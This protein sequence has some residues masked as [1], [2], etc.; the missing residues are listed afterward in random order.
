VAAAAASG[1]VTPAGAPVSDANE[2]RESLAAYLCNAP[3]AATDLGNNHDLFQ[4]LP[5]HFR[6]GKI[7][8]LLST[9]LW[10]RHHA[11][12]YVAPAAMIQPNTHLWPDIVDYCQVITITRANAAV[13]PVN[14]ASYFNF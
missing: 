1:F 4:F 3:D 13:G 9:N 10:L 8:A 12:G 5:A 7:D 14:C 2:L 6:D 11:H